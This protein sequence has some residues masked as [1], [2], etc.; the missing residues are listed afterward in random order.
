MPEPDEDVGEVDPPRA[1]VDDVLA[2]SGLGLRHLLD[3]ELLRPA[4][5]LED[6]RPLD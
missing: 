1:D 5:A 6:E 4:D 3:D 2:L